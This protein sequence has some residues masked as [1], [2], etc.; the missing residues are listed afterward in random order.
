[1]HCAP[2]AGQPCLDR[3]IAAARRAARAARGW[4]THIG[5]HDADD[6]Q[7]LVM[8]RWMKRSARFD[9]KGAASAETYIWTVAQNVV[10]DLVRREQTAQRGE[11]RAPLSL[12][13]PRSPYSDETLGASLPDLGDAETFGA[14]ID[15]VLLKRAIDEFRRALPPRDRAILDALGER[16][17]VHGLAKLLGLPPSTVYDWL[18]RIRRQAEDAGLRKFL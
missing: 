17:N 11:G 4:R 3:E 9:H 5:G 13:R 16:P 7:Q 10:R 2:D 15:R 6:I 18:E 14:G 1:V 8:E 12:D